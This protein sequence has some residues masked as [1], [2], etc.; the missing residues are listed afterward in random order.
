MQRL[1][2]YRRRGFVRPMTKRFGKNDIWFLGI[3]SVLLLGSYVLFYTLGGSKGAIAEVTVAGEVYGSYSLDEEQTIEIK[4]NGK[5]TN[6]LKI[7]NQTA[8]ITEAKCPDHLCVNQRAISK[9]KE[10]LVCLPNQVVV[11]IK[12]AEASDIDSMT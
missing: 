1:L 12:G 8:D 6:I 3:V 2:L 10:T 11:E 4:V 7:Q 9:E 5:V